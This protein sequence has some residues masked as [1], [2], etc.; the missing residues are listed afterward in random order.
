LDSLS[1]AGRPLFHIG[2][3]VFPSLTR[4][5]ASGEPR[6]CHERI[7]NFSQG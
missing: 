5:P 1:S 6:S 4:P 3:V 7:D 2:H